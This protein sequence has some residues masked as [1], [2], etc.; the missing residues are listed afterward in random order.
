MKYVR[1]ET[2]C[3]SIKKVEKLL[4]T[5]KRVVETQLKTNFKVILHKYFLLSEFFIFHKT[6][7]FI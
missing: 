7:T 1:I 2:G 4:K 5:I 6:I 3:H